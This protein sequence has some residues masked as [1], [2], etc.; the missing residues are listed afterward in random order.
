MMIYLITI[1]EDLGWKDF[2]EIEMYH[3]SNLDYAV[4]VDLWG[5][6]GMARH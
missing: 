5:Q 4:F 6:M 3:V 2:T 1:R